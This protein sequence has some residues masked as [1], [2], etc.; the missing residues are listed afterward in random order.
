MISIQ[1]MEN[2]SSPYFSGTKECWTRT[3]R[4]FFGAYIFWM[5]IGLGTTFFHVGPNDLAKWISAEAI[6][7][8]IYL[9]FAVG[10]PI[11]MLLAACNTYGCLV[12]IWGL[13]QATRW[14]LCILLLSTLVEAVGTRVGFPFGSYHYT[15]NF[16]PMLMG[17]L[18]VTISFA[19]FVILS[20]SVLVLQFVHGFSSV[21]V[22]A[23]TA[24]MATFLDWVM[25]PFA[26]QVKHYW[27]WGTSN[28]MPPW[29]NYIAWWV[30]SFL[31][32]LCFAPRRKI[33]ASIDACPMV[34]LGTILLMFILGVH[35]P[36]RW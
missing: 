12:R 3:D 1:K 28:Q 24:T 31:L 4:F 10:D 32:V 30:I 14:T 11:L 5:S 17:V 33:S 18:P 34:L 19:W 27:V 21:T 22:A 20:N 2:H 16:G 15:H 35:H 8:F 7:T 29:Q 26:V 13:K 36:V 6:Q 23:G 25:E 9:C